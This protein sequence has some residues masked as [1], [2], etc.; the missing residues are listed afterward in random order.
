MTPANQEAIDSDRDDETLDF[1][2]DPA[3][4]IQ[5]GGEDAVAPGSTWRCSGWARQSTAAPLSLASRWN[6]NSNHP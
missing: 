1:G 5:V 4:A 6:S 2:I 3:V